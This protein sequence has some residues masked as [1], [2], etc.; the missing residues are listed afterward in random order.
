MLQRVPHGFSNW[1][2][3]VWQAR[4][5][6]HCLQKVYKTA[7]SSGRNFKE[8]IPKMAFKPGD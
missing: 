8:I 4:I 1:Q 3:K 5:V 2:V 6:N 7:F